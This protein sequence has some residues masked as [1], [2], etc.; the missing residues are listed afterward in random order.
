MRSLAAALAVLAVIALA[1]LARAQES[2]EE[3]KRRILE[4]VKERLDREK[5]V[6]LDRVAASIDEELGGKAPA[7]GGGTPDA[8]VAALEKRLAE[9][10]DQRDDLKR[11]IRSIRRETQDAD[12]IKKSRDYADDLVAA[13]KEQDQA[14]L[15]EAVEAISADFA[16]FNRDHEAK[17]YEKSIAGFKRMYYGLRDCPVRQIAVGTGGPAAYNVACGYALMGK[18]EEAIDWLEMAVKLGWQNWPHMKTDSDLDSLRK[19]RRFQRIGPAKGKT[20]DR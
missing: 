15:Q 19:E 13:A 4:K 14:G 8:R 17:D 11:D 7:G 20:V 12:I 6:I 16:A 18:T 10:E 1:P 3:I 2:D 5:K 9:L